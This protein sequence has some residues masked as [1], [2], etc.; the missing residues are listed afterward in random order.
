MSEEIIIN[1]IL[2]AGIIGGVVFVVWGKN[3][4][5]KRD[6]RFKI[7]WKDNRK[8]KWIPGLLFNLLGIG[9]FLISLSYWSAEDSV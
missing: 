3:L 2:K 7:G 1:W 4:I 8:P 5:G 6:K 9:W